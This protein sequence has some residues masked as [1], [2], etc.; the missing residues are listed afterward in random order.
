MLKEKF[1]KY[2]RYEKNCSSH[3]EIS[4]FKDLAQFQMYVESEVGQFDPLTIGSDLIRMWIVHLMEQGN[5][6]STV[7]RKLSTI[8]SFYRYLQKKEM[9]DVNPA[10]YLQGPKKE[11]QLPNF[12]K[13]SDMLKVLSSDSFTDDFEGVRNLFLIELLYLTGLRTDELVM[14]KDIDI[15]LCSNTMHV[16]GK[17]NKDRIIPISPKTNLLF[18]EYIKVR[19]HDVE[20][21]TPYLF[22]RKN[23]KQLYH[24]MVYAIVNKHLSDVKTLSVKSPHVLRHSFATVMLDNGAEINAVKNLLGHASLSSTQIYTHVTFK[25]LKKVYNNAHP[26]A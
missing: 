3:T 5:K 25:K 2:L 14:L 7:N 12:V 4:Y 20:N 18:L 8:K 16:H 19:N 23:G 10:I 22:V 26:R 13:H 9:L 1:I 21:R 11:Q 24:R 6:S 15:D 17:R